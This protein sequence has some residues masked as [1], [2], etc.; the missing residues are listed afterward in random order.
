M[1]KGSIIVDG[2]NRYPILNENNIE[3]KIENVEDFLRK[4]CTRSDV[5]Q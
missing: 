3:F 5:M 1:W 2:H 4:D